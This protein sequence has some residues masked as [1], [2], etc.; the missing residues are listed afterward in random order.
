MWIVNHFPWWTFGIYQ[1][2]CVP[3]R[4]G[5]AGRDPVYPIQ[6]NW[7]DKL[8]YVGREILGIEYIDVTAELDHWVYGP[9]HVWTY[10]ESGQIIRMWQP[11]NG[12]QIYPEGVGK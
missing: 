8:N 10:P 12:L 7:V 9:H 4:E 5:G 11:F 1:C 3:I 6:Y 2:V